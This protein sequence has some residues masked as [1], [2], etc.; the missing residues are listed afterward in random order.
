MDVT[1][2]KVA[3]GVNLLEGLDQPV[4]VLVAHGYNVAPAHDSHKIAQF[5]KNG[6]AQSARP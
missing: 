5:V 4:F 2:R 3:K 6:L 1:G